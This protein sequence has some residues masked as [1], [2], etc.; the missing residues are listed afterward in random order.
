MKKKIFVITIAVVILAVGAFVIL[1]VSGTF[2]VPEATTETTAETVKV[3]DPPEE[4]LDGHFKL[5]DYEGTIELFSRD[6][7]FGPITDIET[8]LEKTE[9]LWV[10]VYGR[11]VKNEKPYLVY[12]DKEVG[13]W[14]VTGTFHNPQGNICGGVAYILVDHE[15]GDVLAVWHDK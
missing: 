5:S 7:N 9:T 14:L 1:M 6:E 3:T 10:E 2:G 8:L 13:A 4:E 15:T 12:F 11:N